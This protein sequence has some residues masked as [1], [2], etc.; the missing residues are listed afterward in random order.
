MGD[1][2]NTFVCS[3]LD[4]KKIILTT[5][6]DDK[7]C[8]DYI[9]SLSEKKCC[10]NVSVLKIQDNPSDHYPVVGFNIDLYNT[11]YLDHRHLY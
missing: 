2:N 4:V 6:I 9:I 11:N 10:G 1:L 5:F 7:K 3:I 8:F